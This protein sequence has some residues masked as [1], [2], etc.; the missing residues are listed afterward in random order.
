MATFL[1]GFKSLLGIKK[2]AMGLDVFQSHC[3]KIV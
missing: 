2:E 3:L 1:R